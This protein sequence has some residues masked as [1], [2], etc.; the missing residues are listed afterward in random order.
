MVR[1][2]VWAVNDYTD[3]QQRVFPIAYFMSRAAAVRYLGRDPVAQSGLIK[4]IRVYDTAKEK[5]AEQKEDLRRKALNKL[6][7]EE[8]EALGLPR[9][10]DARKYGGGQ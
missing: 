7:M 2:T 8:L 5:R 4:D 9:L 6:R 1:T 3:D 10:P